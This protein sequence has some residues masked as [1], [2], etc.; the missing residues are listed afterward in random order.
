[1]S[2]SD[3]NTQGREAARRALA[4]SRR[5]SSQ[6]DRLIKATRTELDKVRA[7][8]ETNHFTNKFRAI[9]RGAA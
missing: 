6:A 5:S 3:E 2:S 4:E 9:L 1:M 7:S 8:R